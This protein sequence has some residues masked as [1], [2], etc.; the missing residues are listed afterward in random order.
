MTSRGC[1]DL[2]PSIFSQG[3]SC[4]LTKLQDASFPSAV[5][6]LVCAFLLL[7]AP[8]ESRKL[9]GPPA[10]GC[11]VG[12]CSVV[13]CAEAHP[14]QHAALPPRR[15]LARR[16]LVSWDLREPPV[17]DKHADNQAEPQPCVREG[18]FCHAL[19]GQQ[20]GAIAILRAH[21][22]CPSGSGKC[23]G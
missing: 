15:E 7:L 11:C 18:R 12:G 1:W 4:E 19:H 20:R 3:C 8:G 6:L 14:P 2:A 16:S 23:P 9:P 10:S 13:L 5:V 21:N 22:I 17:E